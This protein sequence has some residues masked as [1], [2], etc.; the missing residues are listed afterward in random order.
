MRNGIS[1]MLKSGKF[2]MKNGIFAIKTAH[3]LNLVLTQVNKTETQ[4][5]CQV[6]LNPTQAQTHCQIPLNPTQTQTHCQVPLNQ[7]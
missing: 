3:S 2:I 7:T 1:K 6:P 4:T 5:H